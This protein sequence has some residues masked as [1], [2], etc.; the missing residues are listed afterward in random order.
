MESG[1]I[2]EVHRSEVEETLPELDEIKDKELRDKVIDAWA[3]ALVECD[4]ESLDQLQFGAKYD[5]LDY[6]SQVNHTREV[7]QCAITLTETLIDSRDLDVDRDA[8]VAGALLHD[9]SKFHETSPTQKEKTELGEMVPHPHYGIH[10][11]AEAGLSHH[12]QHIVLVHTHASKPQPKTI[13]AQL[14]V[15]ADLAAADAIFWDN[16][17]EVHFDIQAKVIH[18]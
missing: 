15:L 8:I 10:M 9:I 6:E 17:E 16:L 4:Y 3:K 18:D 5:E 7:T 2:A 14:V 13:E 1:K 11:L 12:I